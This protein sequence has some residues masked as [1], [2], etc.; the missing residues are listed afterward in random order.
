M[1][2]RLTALQDQIQAMISQV[3]SP[4]LDST[5]AESHHRVILRD[6]QS[7]SSSPSSDH[8][9]KKRKSKKI[10]LYLFLLSAK[11]GGE[12]RQLSL[13]PPVPAKQDEVS[14]ENRLSRSRQRNVRKREWD[15]LMG[16]HLSKRSRKFRRGRALPHPT[17]CFFLRQ[18][19]MERGRP[20]GLLLQRTGN[21][22]RQSV[23]SRPGPKD[24][25]GTRPQSRPQYLAVLVCLMRFARGAYTTGGSRGFCG[26]PGTGGIFISPL[27]SFNRVRSA[28]STFGGS[29][30]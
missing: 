8:S 13:S 4:A 1:Q 11:G 28:S 7:H 23:L 22:A 20:L 9:S 25:T 19:L 30:E 12:A 29:F 16:A 10:L 3:V 15:A 27:C 21:P 17:S 2:E 14:A 6:S 24:R 26:R 18:S 5:S